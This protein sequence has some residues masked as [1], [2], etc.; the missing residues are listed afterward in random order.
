MLKKIVYLPLDERPCN[1]A[2]ASFLSENNPDYTLV[3]PSLEILGR[4]KQEANHEEIENFL[5]GECKDAYGLVVSVD[6]LLYGGIV[7][8]R[9]HKLR[10]EE[11][12]ERL[13]LL[14]KL[15]K[16]NPALKIYAFALIMRCPCYSS[17]DEEPDYYETYGRRIFLHGQAEHK[18]A[19][20]IIS[21][22]EFAAFQAENTEE[23]N[24]F[25]KDFLHRRR[26]NLHTL[27]ELLRYVGTTVD[28][29]VIPQDDSAPYGYTALDQKKV[30]DFILKNQ[31]QEIDIYPGADEV[32]MTL[33]SAM[34]VD[35]KKKAPKICPVFPK[36]GC[37]E[38]IPLYEDRPVKRSIKSQI[39]NAG[40]VYTEKEADA[41]ILL[42]CNLPDG[43]MKNSSEQTDENGNR[44]PQ[45]VARD[46]PAFT[47]KM[48]TSLAK[49]IQVAAADLAY[50]N[51]GDE[52]WVKMIAE[53]IGVFRLSGYAG[54]NT[55][56]NSLGTVICQA[57]LFYY[58]GNT[59][60]HKAFL[61]ERVIEDVGYCGFA[62]K[63]I[64]DNLLPAMGY[65]YFHADG[66]KGEVSALV[67]KTLEEY[68]K[69]NFPAIAERFE[70][71]DCEMPW[72]R[73]FE[74]GLTVKE[75]E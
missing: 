61:A 10:A 3:R 46:L 9:M 18:Y 40:G 50:C 31:I 11:L 41:D 65:D 16:E 56:S 15:K 33:L 29:L 39:V 71:V 64:C 35:M 67:Q 53:Q 14:K 7:P 48:A 44:F 58:Y 57:V 43:Q 70:I 49:G 20:G 45:Y 28:K 24:G 23:F 22:E 5:I 63:Y 55:S 47:K 2:F 60:T 37:S 32:G 8:S 12:D 17:S 72:S 6:M 4:K 68:T 51:G 1:Y 59:P 74:V 30:R 27:F 19:E 34:V 54:W 66:Q 26:R 73:M 52:E 25:L 38:I 62:R 13:S 21:K 42:F 75:R 69:E 36:K